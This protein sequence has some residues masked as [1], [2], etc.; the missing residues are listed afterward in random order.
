MQDRLVRPVV[1]ADRRRTALPLYHQLKDL[2]TEKIEGGEWSPGHQLPTELDLAREFGV[3]RTTVRQAMYL[4][5]NEGLVE[6]FQGKGTFVGRPKIAQNLASMGTI[7]RDLLRPS[8]ASNLQ[9]V[10]LKTM[11]APHGVAAQLKLDREERVHELRRTLV[12]NGEPLFLV[13]VW[14]PESRFPD[15]EKRFTSEVTMRQLLREAFGVVAI[16]QHKEVEVTILNEEEAEL[17]HANPG[18]PALQIS[19]LSRSRDSGEPV[20]FRRLVVRGDRCKYYVD[21]DAPE[22]LV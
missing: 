18:A 8:V 9:L 13:T 10:H 21:L 19:Y 7:G 6:R 1:T 3:S 22:L 16:R 20:E 11:V 14:L 17:L 4:L 2:I 5:E 15:F 12:V